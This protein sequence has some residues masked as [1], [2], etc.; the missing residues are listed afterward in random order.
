MLASTLI[1]KLKR[2]SPDTLIVLQSDA[3]GNGYSPL[4]SVDDN[5]FYI[6]DNSWSGE[7]YSLR[8]LEE[9]QDNFIK[10]CILTP[11]N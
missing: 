9:P 1:E 7:V 5:L 11:I 6:P 3:E 4:S 2:L 8:D 10:C